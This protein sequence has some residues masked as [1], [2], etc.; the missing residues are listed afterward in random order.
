MLLAAAACILYH[1]FRTMR[2]SSIFVFIG[3]AM[4]GICAAIASTFFHDGLSSR[5]RPTKMEIAI[6]RKVRHLAIPSSVRATQNP[7]L[8]S[9]EDLRE[10]RLH[11]A[12][13][14]AMCHDNDGGG[15]TMIGRGLYPKPPDLRLPETQN[16]SD[17]EIFWIIENG[18][19]FTGMPAFPPEEHDGTGGNHVADMENWKLVHFIRHLPHL[20]V[21][22]RMEMEHYN[23][24]GPDDRQEE[25]QENDF[26]NG[27]TPKAKP[28]S[29]NGTRK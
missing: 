26:L 12:D 25:E 15:N 1:T 6:A 27:A 5:A 29:Q 23:P 11:F 20:S 13:H 17:G 21:A 18:V 10:A 7:L 8:D 22:E 28:E 14:C 2:R 3:V 4:L 19:R 9:A 24:R 16:L